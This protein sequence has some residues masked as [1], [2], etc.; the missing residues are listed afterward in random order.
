M[1]TLSYEITAV[2]PETK[3]MEILYTSDTY[4]TMTISGRM[5]F[6]GEDLAAVVAMY[7]PLPY[8]IE[9]AKAV[10]AVAVGTTGLL[11]PGGV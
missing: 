5:P 7:S 6:E 8:W 11:S 10:A 9:Q 4:G 3:T 1:T 2:Y